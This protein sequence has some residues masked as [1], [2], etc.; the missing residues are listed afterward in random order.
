MAGWAKRIKFN[1]MEAINQFL[2]QQLSGRGRANSSLGE[3]REPCCPSFLV[4]LSP[5]VC[6]FLLGTPL[7]WSPH[8]SVCRASS[9]SRPASLNSGPCLLHS[10]RGPFSGLP[11]A[12]HLGTAPLD[13]WGLRRAQT[14]AHFTGLLSGTIVL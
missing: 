9:L 13:S 11:P 14:I 2:L 5:V 1:M 3:L 7:C 4:A 6:H 12:L 10:T 8:F